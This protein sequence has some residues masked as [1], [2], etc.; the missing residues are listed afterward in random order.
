MR[1]VERAVLVIVRKSIITV[2][3]IFQSYIEAN[4]YIAAF[5]IAGNLLQLKLDKKKKNVECKLHSS[6]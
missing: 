1:K 4:I 3:I 6:F 5:S 2:N